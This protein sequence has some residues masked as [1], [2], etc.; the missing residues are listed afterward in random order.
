MNIF[1]AIKFLWTGRNVINDITK[2]AVIMDSG[3]PGWKTSE[4]WAKVLTVDVPMLVGAAHGV[5]PVAIAS[6]VLLGSNVAYMLLR[7]WLKRSAV[8]SNVKAILAEVKSGDLSKL[9][10]VVD[11][12]T[13]DQPVSATPA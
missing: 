4:F 13:T 3:K 5:I 12:L 1:Q 7:T 2:E 9:N 8:M 11:T 10:T 6:Y